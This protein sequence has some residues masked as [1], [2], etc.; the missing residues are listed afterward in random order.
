M[1]NQVHS[2]LTPGNCTAILVDYQPQ[3]AFAVH[4]I[5]DQ[6]LLNNTVGLARA[7][8]VFQVPTILTTVEAESFSGKLFPQLLEIFPN[9]T[10]ID[11]T[12]M[13]CWED[14]NVLNEV[15]KIGRKKLIECVPL[16]SEE[17][18]QERSSAGRAG[19]Q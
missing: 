17:I 8:R 1:P 6:T 10:P 5:D 12:T 9:Q 18:Q 11:R 3:M 7:L 19:S 2:L 13:N 4:S 15:K 16:S 14:S